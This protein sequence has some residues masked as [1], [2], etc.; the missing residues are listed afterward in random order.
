MHIANNY[1]SAFIFTVFPI[2][3]CKFIHF[4]DTII[5]IN[6]FFIMAILCIFFE[7]LGNDIYGLFTKI[8][9]FIG[10]YLSK[11][12]LFIIWITAVLPTGILMKLTG[13]DRLNLKKKNVDSYWKDNKIQNT[14]Y[15]NQF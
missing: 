9:K 6:T 1:K 5:I 2:V 12:I 13:R 11:I 8:G 3:L 4:I 14:D 15:E 7:R 10:K